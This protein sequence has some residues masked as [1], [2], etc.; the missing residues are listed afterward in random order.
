MANGIIISKEG[1]FV[2]LSKAILD[3][4]DTKRYHATFLHS[5]ETLSFE[6]QATIED[7]HLI[8]AKLYTPGS[9]TPIPFAKGKLISQKNLSF[10]TLVW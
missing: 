5:E 2:I 7:E 6:F 8:F 3:S 4:K 1:A 9:F 10:V